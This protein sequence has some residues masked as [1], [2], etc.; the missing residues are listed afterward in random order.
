MTQS[1]QAVAVK[2]SEQEVAK[3]AAVRLNGYLKTHGT[4]SAVIRHLASKGM[5]KGQIA[6]EIGKRYQHV[7]N[8]LL[9]PVANP[10]VVTP[11]GT[12]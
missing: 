11:T 9:V 3:E 4:I 7:R 12:K 8:V 1:N 2:K 6:K 10:K 5:S